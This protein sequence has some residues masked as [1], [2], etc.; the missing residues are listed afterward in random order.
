VLGYGLLAARA[1]R[2]RVRTASEGD[3]FG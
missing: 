1:G 3:G 2:G